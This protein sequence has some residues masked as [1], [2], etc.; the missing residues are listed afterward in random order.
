VGD[1]RAYWLLDRCIGVRRF[2]LEPG[3]TTTAAAEA[4]MVRDLQRNR[5]RWLVLT[6]PEKGDDAFLRKSGA[7]L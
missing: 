6:P 3:V 1:I 7:R 5:V 2:I 4:E